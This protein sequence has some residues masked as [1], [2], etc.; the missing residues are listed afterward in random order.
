[1]PSLLLYLCICLLRKD[2][3]IPGIWWEGWMRRRVSMTAWK[4]AGQHIATRSQGLDIFYFNRVPSDKR[5]LF[6][7]VLLRYTKVAKAGHAV[8]PSGVQGN[9]M[10][11]LSCSK[12]APT[13]ACCFMWVVIVIN[14]KDVVHLWTQSQQMWW[15][16]YTHGTLFCFIFKTYGTTASSKETNQNEC[17]RSFILGHFPTLMLRSVHQTAPKQRSYTSMPSRL[18]WR[19]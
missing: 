19:R 6:K 8:M 10:M 13:A 1:M 15:L 18:T 9:E 3:N 14:S 12:D 4:H 5:T 16:S 7:A 2:R 17:C 11:I